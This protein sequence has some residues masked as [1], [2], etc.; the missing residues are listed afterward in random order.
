MR[1]M[2]LT[3]LLAGVPFMA[4]ETEPGDPSNA[5]RPKATGPLSAQESKLQGVWQ[6]YNVK[7]NKKLY[8]MKFEGR[9]FRADRGDEWYE[10]YIAIRTDTEPA[11]LDF[12]IE[13]CACGFKGRTSTGIFYWDGE[14]IVVSG[15]EPG[16]A[17]PQEFKEAGGSMFRL[18]REGRD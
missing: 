17:R 14:M 3:I 13:D 10:G 18:K 11:H 6:A 15:P 4:A 5:D 7:S 16:D 12:M 8:K 9:D 2:L 1:V